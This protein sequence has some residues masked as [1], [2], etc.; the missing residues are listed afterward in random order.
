[1]AGREGE[2][3]VVVLGFGAVALTKLETA[4]SPDPH[5]RNTRK[6]VNL[7]RLDSTPDRLQ[8][9]GSLGDI[10]A[11]LVF[12]LVTSEAPIAGN[13]LPMKAGEHEVRPYPLF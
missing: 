5:L 1:M 7:H 9:F 11:N 4:G 6:G 13:G 10:G 3:S 12:A 8:R 2:S